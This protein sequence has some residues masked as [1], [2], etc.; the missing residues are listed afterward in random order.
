MTVATL[1][2]VSF[3]PPG[4]T[5]PAL[6]DVSHTFSAGTITL[7]RGASG[8]GKSTL[9]RALSGLVPH[10]HGGTFQG[11]VT[12][13][14]HD[15]RRASVAEIGQVVGSVFQDPETQ[16]IRGTARS[17][18][19]FGLEC[20]AV[21]SDA[22]PGAVTAAL[23]RVGAEHLADR[24]IASLS[25][26][27]RQ[28]VAIAGA[29]AVRPKLLTLDE[30]TSQLDDAGSAALCRALEALAAE[31]MSIVVAEHNDHR[32]PLTVDETI[33]MDHGRFT[34]PVPAPTIHPQGHP[35]I[36]DVSLSLR[37]VSVALGE[38]PILRACTLDVH[39]HEIVAIVGA[40]GSGKST[41]L[42]TAVGLTSP[43]DGRVIVNGR[44]IT[45]DPTEVRAATMAFLPQDAGRRLL[46]ERVIDE[47][48]NTPW[49][50]DDRVTRA[51]AD[52]DLTTFANRHPL[53]LSVGERERVAIATVVAA[54]RPVMLL[55][56]PTRGMDPVR[57][58]RLAETLIRHAAAGAAIVV[59]THD[60]HLA[61][62]AH[63]VVTMRDGV[64]QKATTPAGVTR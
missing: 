33:W 56:E 2:H 48:A 30:P 63:R 34:A 54:G 52:G 19:A 13:V 28:R 39:A 7:V 55:D 57:R 23:A 22:I 25:G 50:T 20:H 46:T 3:W 59:A 12:V 49:A 24:A 58:Q 36:G 40:N 26:G 62:M 17:D 51:L 60:H 32:L 37:E 27:E 10:F 29:L 11:R 5:T 43:T 53:D 21:A 4:A 31:G 64:L 16:T 6:D 15:T 38:R 44:D 35:Q 41:L 18:V 45:E 8:S 61:Q 47:V 14:G 42:R 9:L 1:D